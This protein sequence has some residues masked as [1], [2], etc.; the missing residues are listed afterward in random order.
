MDAM[1]LR[2]L[3]ITLLTLIATLGASSGLFAYMIKKVE[4][5][6][7]KVQMILGLAHDRLV[8]LSLQ[9]ID[10]GSITSDEYENLVKYLYEPYKEL[11]GNG[12]AEHLINRVS[13]L[14]IVGRT[15]FEK[16]GSEL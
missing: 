15:Y 11:G 2:Y 7:V 13:K 3:I 9:Y 8:Y 16:N 4:K 12:A 6:D 1:E 14:K 5:R 10:R